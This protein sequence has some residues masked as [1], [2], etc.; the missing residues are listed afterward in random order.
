ML[1]LVR[2]EALLLNLGPQNCISTSRI[3]NLKDYLYER[4][5]GAGKFFYIVI[6]RTRRLQV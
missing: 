2:E 3:A 1:S 6:I 4:V 5:N